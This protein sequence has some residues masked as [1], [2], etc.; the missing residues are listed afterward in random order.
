[1][2]EPV[3]KYCLRPK[4]DMV[5]VGDDHICLECALARS[6]CNWRRR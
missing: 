2:V 6:Y 5:R 1:M 4:P 3:C